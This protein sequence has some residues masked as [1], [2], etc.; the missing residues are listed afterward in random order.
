M[1]QGPDNVLVRICWSRIEQSTFF[2]Q[3]IFRVLNEKEKK[4]I[5]G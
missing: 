1:F 5:H 2:F 4:S 3:K